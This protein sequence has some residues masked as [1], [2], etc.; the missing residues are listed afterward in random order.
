MRRVGV[1]ISAG[2][3]TAIGL[4]YTT[5]IIHQLFSNG[6]FLSGSSVGKGGSDTCIKPKSEVCAIIQPATSCIFL[7][8]MNP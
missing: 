8:C 4:T 7:H 6:D 2:A 1:Y 5:A 3:M